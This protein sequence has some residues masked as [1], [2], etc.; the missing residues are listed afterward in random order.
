MVMLDGT[1]LVLG[2]SC[3]GRCH[4]LTAGG[5]WACLDGRRESGGALSVRDGLQARHHHLRRILQVR[6]PRQPLLTPPG[7]A[8]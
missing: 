7:D 1:V 5:V 8:H 4:V 2:D 6:P 3:A